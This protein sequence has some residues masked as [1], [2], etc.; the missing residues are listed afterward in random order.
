MQE[1]SEPAPLAVTANPEQCTIE[2]GTVD[3]DPAFPYL[4]GNVIVTGGSLHPTGLQPGAPLPDHFHFE[5]MSIMH[6]DQ[7]IPIG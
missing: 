5:S 7:S 6:L 2:R 4:D 1:S 3:S